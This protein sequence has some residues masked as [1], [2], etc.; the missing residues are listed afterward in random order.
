MRRAILTICFM[1]LIFSSSAIAAENKY[2]YSSGQILTGE[3]WENVYVYND[4]TVVD[5]LGGTIVNGI[6]S[7]NASTVNIIDGHLDGIASH[8]ASTV[9][10]TGG[11]AYNVQPQDFSTINVTGGNVSGLMSWDNST[12]TLSG[13]ANVHSLS[14]NNY[15]TL[16]VN[17]GL[18]SFLGAGGNGTV[19]LFGGKITDYLDADDGSIVNIHGNNLTKFQTGGKFGFGYVHGFWSDKEEF[20]ITL[21]S[22]EAYTHINLIPE[23]A[24]VLLF[25]FGAVAL[26]RKR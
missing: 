3:Q 17:S 7:Y 4:S 12:I 13:D 15:G 18:I 2:F 10:I 20:I 9:N 1:V 21:S 8:N 22:S 14:I 26:R 25:G 16:L 5:M 23:P 19:N 24:S 6:F 11:Q